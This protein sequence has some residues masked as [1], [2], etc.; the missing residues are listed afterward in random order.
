MSNFLVEAGKEKLTPVCTDAD[1]LVKELR[2]FRRTAV[3]KTN[4]S[5]VELLREDRYGER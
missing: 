5:A 4:K 1:E 2:E 3:K